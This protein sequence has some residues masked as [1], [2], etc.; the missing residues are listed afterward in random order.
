MILFFA[1]PLLS[2]LSSPPL[3]YTIL[4]KVSNFLKEIKFFPHH[5]FIG[6]ILSN[7]ISLGYRVNLTVLFLITKYL[8]GGVDQSGDG[9][10]VGGVGKVVHGFSV[11]VGVDVVLVTLTVSTVFFFQRVV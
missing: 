10:G 3:C 2:L 6:S 9:R 7:I 4:Y 5:D 1:Y 8:F 11:D